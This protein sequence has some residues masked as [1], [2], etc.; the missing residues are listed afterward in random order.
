MIISIIE[1]ILMEKKYFTFDVAT[2][3]LI[4]SFR[5]IQFAITNFFQFHAP[6]RNGTDKTAW[7]TIA[8]IWIFWKSKRMNSFKLSAVS[9]LEY[10]LGFFHNYKE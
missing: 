3:F 5:T 1:L 6:P 9:E 2:I 8:T 7:K 10:N 4:F